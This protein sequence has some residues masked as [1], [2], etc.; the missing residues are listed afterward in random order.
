MT[1]AVAALA[2]CAKESAPETS[3]VKTVNFT[4]TTDDTK[5][6]FTD[7][8]A[9]KYPTIWNEGDKVRVNQNNG[10][11]FSTAEVTPTDGGKKASY[12]IDVTE[13]TSYKFFAVSPASAFI[14][15]GSG[16]NTFNID[17]IASQTPS[18][19]SVDPAAQ[20]LYGTKDCGSTCPSTISMSMHHF[21][22]YALVSFSNLNLG[23][24]KINSVSVTAD[25]NIA[26]RFLWTPASEKFEVKSGSKT[27]SVTTSSASNIW[28]AVAP[29]A[30]TSLKFVVGTDKGTFTKEVSVSKSFTS[31]QVAKINVNMNGIPLK[32]PVKYVRVKTAADLAAKVGYEFIIGA[33]TSNY[34]ISINQANNRTAAAVTKDGD[35]ILNPADNVERFIL[36]EGSTSGYSFY[37]Q[38]NSGYLYAV[39]K[40]STS[41]NNYMK[42][43]ATKNNAASWNISFKEGVASVV[44]IDSSLKGTMQYNSNNGAPIFSCYA[45]A[46]DTR[47]DIALYTLEGGSPVEKK[48]FGVDKT[49]ISAGADDTSASFKV[50]GNVA[51]TISCPTGV[52]ASPASG[53]GA[54]DISL[55]F[56]KNTGTTAKEYEITVATEDAKIST[57]EITVTLT[58]S[59]KGT[60]TTIATILSECA[61]LASGQTSSSTYSL[62][63]VTVMAAAK[64]Y[65]IFGDSTGTIV[66]YKSNS[67]LS[68][69]NIV[70]V[71]GATV[72]NYSNL[73]EIS[74]A[75]VDVQSGSVTPVHGTAAQFTSSGISSYVSSTP[76]SSKYAH[77][78]G[79]LSGFEVTV[80][81]TEVIVNLFSNDDITEHSG[82]T[83]DV[84]G[85]A[86]GYN[87]SSKKIIFAVT[88]ISSSGKTAG[89][90]TAAST[91]TL[92]EGEAWTIG[93]TSNSGA[94][95]TYSSN[96]TAAATVDA[97]TGK[98][99]AVKKGTATITMT[100]P[101]TEDYTEATATC[102]VTVE[103]SSLKTLSMDFEKATSEYS[104]F[105]FDKMLSKQT[106]TNLTAYGGSYFGTNGGVTSCSV[107]TNNKISAPKSIT[108][109]ASKLSTNTNAAA[110]K[111]EVSTDNEKWTTVAS[112]DA[113]SVTKGKWT[114]YK[115]DL[116]SYSNVY[117]RICY[118]GNTAVRAID[119]I[120]IKYE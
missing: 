38:V 99:T 69:G 32:T 33:A 5:T 87:S 70:N 43:Q 84:Y 73:L 71:S 30:V 118:D 109:Y 8:T 45:A 28:F 82:K 117:V 47:E 58:Q 12:S 11:K 72:K 96:N 51:W 112:H 59:A 100:C 89:V 17:I 48:S 35:Y 64:Q 34:A 105:T 93:A 15:T 6:S 62:T 74:S 81:G 114:E 94:V 107:Q 83:V 20:V 116:S 13:A 49:A 27:V 39:T 79:T 113:A 14:G 26:G 44:C 57:K 119:D 101:A 77:V 19:T 54:A 18:E 78:T 4:L 37:A 23:E 67:G 2:S 88:S 29:S 53:T 3:G 50:T 10:T 63:G 120:T 95:V 7:L 36:E 106:N 1:A 92:T 103:D 76:Y 108:F 25:A 65:I 115:T 9:G 21:S 22:A 16:D 31:G 40:T 98:V 46:A 104:N 80:E 86:A 66:Y 85:Y 102:V 24:A 60:T 97:S 55:S 42:T 75:T 68:V 41:S 52:T 56:A 110:W 90:I 61:T 111:V 91:K